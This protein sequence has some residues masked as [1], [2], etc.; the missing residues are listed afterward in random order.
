VENIKIFC[1]HPEKDVA[2]AETRLLSHK[3]R[4]S[5]KRCDLYRCARN[6]KVTG[7][8]ARGGKKID[9]DDDN[10]THMQNCPPLKGRNTKV[11]M[12]GEVPD[13]I[14]PVKF[15]IDRFRGF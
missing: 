1:S 7:G 15:N 13:V 3:T 5:I 4:K 14:T 11:C 8:G 2:V 6:K 10:F 9:T 12:W